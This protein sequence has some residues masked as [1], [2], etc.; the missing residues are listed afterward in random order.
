MVLLARVQ[1]FV[2]CKSEISTS[3]MLLKCKGLLPR[4]HASA[5]D[6]SGKFSK[7]AKN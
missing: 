7:R 5:V 6:A 4:A 2:P 3:Y 1:S